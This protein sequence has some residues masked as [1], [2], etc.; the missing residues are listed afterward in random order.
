[1]YS[2]L[3]GIIGT[4]GGGIVAGAITAFPAIVG[5][6]ATLAGKADR[7]VDGIRAGLFLGGAF[8]KC[9]SSNCQLFM[10]LLE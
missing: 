7:C 3:A 4:C 5:G 2:P 1:M 8:A 9:A 6:I 10:S